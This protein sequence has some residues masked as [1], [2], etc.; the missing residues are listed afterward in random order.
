MA[1]NKYGEKFPS[2]GVEVVY[3]YRE[4]DRMDGHLTAWSEGLFRA[5]REGKDKPR[6]EES[7]EGGSPEPWRQ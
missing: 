5:N 3:A 6:G 4:L 1:A 2:F 7:A